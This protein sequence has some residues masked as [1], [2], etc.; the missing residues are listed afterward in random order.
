MDRLE[1][2]RTF[3]AIADAG[4]FTRAAAGLRLTPQL[5]SKQLRQLEE[6]LGVQ[7]LQRTTRSVNLTEPG[8]RY[9]DEARGLVEQFDALD[10]GL[11]QTQAALTGRI[12]LTAPTG[13]GGLVIVPAL[14]RFQDAHPGIEIDLALSDRRA[15]LVEEG[16]DLAIRIGA[17]RDSSL[18]QRKLADMP[19]R[20]CA[21][22]DYLARAGTP[23]TPADLADHNCLVNFDLVEPGVWHFQDAGRPLPVRVSGNLRINQPR[24]LADMA[25]AGRGLASQPDY[26]VRADIEAGR[27]V[28]VLDA[29]ARP[30]QAVYA[31]Y[32]SRRFVPAR[33]RALIEFL[34][35]RALA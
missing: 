11:R 33:L 24:A 25:R 3:I 13:Y 9:L 23:R 20:I 34:A 1:Q 7:L 31:L 30:P 15:A 17:P 14:A 5:A 26:T 29:Y 4:S 8:A 27:L 18:I 10:E 19:I 21:S 12:R 35:D 22:P 28:T 32:P 6:R 16:L 2:I